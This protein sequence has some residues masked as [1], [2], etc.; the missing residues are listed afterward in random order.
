M[1]MTVRKQDRLQGN[2][3]VPG[4]NLREP[5][6]AHQVTLLE[7]GECSQPPRSVFFK[8]SGQQCEPLASHAGGPLVRRS[9]R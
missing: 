7:Q 3:V 4:R 5:V 6:S 1:E 8:Q 9:K 2:R